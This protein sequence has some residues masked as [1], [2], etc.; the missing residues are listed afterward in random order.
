[1]V[2]SGRASISAVADLSRA[3]L[4]DMGA[5]VPEAV[6]AFASLGA[7]GTHSQNQER[8]LSRWV[9]QLYGF[10]IQTYGAKIDCQALVEYFLFSNERHVK[11]NLSLRTCL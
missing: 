6:K 7:W 4:S 2:G 8:D 3:C 10:T 11:G 5:A 9:H 1:M